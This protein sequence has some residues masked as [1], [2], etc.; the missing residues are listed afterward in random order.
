[1]ELEENILGSN[2]VLITTYVTLG[3]NLCTWLQW[4]PWRRKW[5][6]TPV[7]LPRKFHGWGSLVGYSPWGRKELDTT[8][9][10]HHNDTTMV[11]H[12][13]VRTSGR[14]TV[15][16]YYVLGGLMETSY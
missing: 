15:L 11:A 3:N 9:R 5:Q 4:L 7:L 12:S 2:L 6:P 14:S 1:M 8:E 10:V 16:V 13:Q